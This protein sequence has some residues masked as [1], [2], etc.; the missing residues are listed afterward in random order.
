MI[1][2]GKAKVLEFNHS[3]EELKE[4][5]DICADNINLFSQAV[6][7]TKDRKDYMMSRKDIAVRELPLAYLLKLSCDEVTTEA[8]FS[9]NPLDWKWYVDNLLRYE[10]LR[11]VPIS[12]LV[13]Q[14]H[15]K[16][17]KALDPITKVIT[18]LKKL[19]EKDYKW[20]Y[21]ELTGKL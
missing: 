5:L 10:Q 16:Y 15:E 3:P 11:N 8:K 18:F 9:K 19:E 14:L 13:S 4:F 7:I 20:C 2:E 6:F 1:K 21:K 17:E 12:E